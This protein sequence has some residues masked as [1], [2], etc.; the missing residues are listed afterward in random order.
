MET[1]GKTEEQFAW[2]DRP[3]WTVPSLLG[4]S[5]LGMTLWPVL[6]VAVSY[7]MFD[8]PSEA[9]LLFGSFIMI[10]LIPIYAVTASELVLGG[11][12]IAIWLGIWTGS[13]LWMASWPRRGQL[14]GLL[15]LSLLSLM[16]AGLGFLMILG[17][18]V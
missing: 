2:T 8:A 3:A 7:T 16:Q 5:L 11:L 1:L 13:S 10:V 17:K 12:V 15:I 9:L 18:A 14:G 6:G 4:M